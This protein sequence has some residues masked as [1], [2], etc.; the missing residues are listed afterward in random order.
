MSRLW[1]LLTAAMIAMSASIVHATPAKA[2]LLAGDVEVARCIRLASNGRG[3]L[4]KTLWGLR[5]QEAG[6][7]GAKIRNADGSY[8]LGPLQINS[9][10]VP[11]IS[12][13]V[14][15][16]ESD[17]W[18]WLQHDACFNVYATRWIFLTELKSV[19]DYWKAIGHYH[20]RVRWRNTRYIQNVGRRLVARFGPA[21]FEK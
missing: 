14:H 19:Q 3:W 16:S 1:G 4:E 6:W 20:S 12:V 8:D 7:V 9:W 2:T 18:T 13:L 5:D 21:A 17:V 10:W 11:R 15:R